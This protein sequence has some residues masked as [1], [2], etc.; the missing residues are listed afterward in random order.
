M[1]RPFRLDQQD[2]CL[3]VC[4]GAVFDAARHDEQLALG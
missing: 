2:V 1:G 3:L 4:L